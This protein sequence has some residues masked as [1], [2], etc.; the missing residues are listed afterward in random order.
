MI[1]HELIVDALQTRLLT[2]SVCTTGS[3]TLEATANGYQRAAGSFLT[4]GF[5]VGMEVTP[6]GFTDTTPRV[7]T[8]VTALT[9][10][11]DGVVTVDA[12]SA[13]RTLAVGLP[14]RRAW[15]N[16]DFT[17]APGNLYVE[18]QY[19]PGANAQLTIGAH[20]ILEMTPLYVAILY[21][22]AN[23]GFL[24][25]Q[26]YG[27]ALLAL[28]APRTTIALSNGDS[29]RVRTNPAPYAGQIRQ[30][31]GGWAYKVV[32]IPLLLHTANAT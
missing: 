25:Q 10:T 20:G 5:A 17:P 23:T 15:E 29:L 26:R 30:R 31:D 18:E 11:V 12:P 32:T 9:M 2:L 1:S 14:S 27:D 28:F 24:A 6:T 13:G 19:I 22:L 8:A 7:I 16:T 21:F 4:D 3:T